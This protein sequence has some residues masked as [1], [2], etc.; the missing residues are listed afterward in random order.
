[1]DDLLNA[2][3]NLELGGVMIQ[4]KCRFFLPQQNVSL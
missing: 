4:T 3:Q 1:M 2:L